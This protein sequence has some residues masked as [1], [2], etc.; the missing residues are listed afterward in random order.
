M[1]EEVFTELTK[2]I[3]KDCLIKTHTIDDNQYCYDLKRLFTIAEI[4]N[5]FHWNHTKEI[6]DSNTMRIKHNGKYIKLI[7]DNYPIQLKEFYIGEGYTLNHN[8]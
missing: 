8:K 3:A 7:L 1:S 2:I 6:K 4:N 5:N